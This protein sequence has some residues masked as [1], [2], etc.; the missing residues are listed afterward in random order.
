[1]LWS[2][3]YTAEVASLISS[4]KF[5][6]FMMYINILMHGHVGENISVM[7]QWSEMSGK[8]TGKNLQAW[9]TTCKSLVCSKGTLT[10]IISCR[11]PFSFCHSF[12]YH[13]SFSKCHS[14]IY[15]FLSYVTSYLRTFRYFSLS[16]V[17]SSFHSSYLSNITSYCHWFSYCHHAFHFTSYHYPH[18]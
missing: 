17:P 16:Y 13:H 6:C 5:L 18:I 14:F 15:S 8:K 2:P 4:L 9:E 3:T 11:H 10:I 12:S 1:M 7:C